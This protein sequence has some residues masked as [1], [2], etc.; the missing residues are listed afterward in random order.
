MNKVK[1][2]Y[3]NL[4][5]IEKTHKLKCFF[6]I[7]EKLPGMSH[8][9]RIEAENK[10]LS[11]KVEEMKEICSL[12]S[13]LNVKYKSQLDKESEDKEFLKESNHKL[14]LR[15]NYLSKKCNEMNERVKVLEVNLNRKALTRINQPRVQIIKSIT[16]ITRFDS[17]ALDDLQKRYDELDTEHKDALN[18]ID[19]LE[20][21]LDDVIALN[22]PC[23]E[24]Y[25]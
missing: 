22:F 21:E 12:T 14:K 11:M 4:H 23:P 5:F 7:V 8:N 6:F 13:T 15:L 20:F 2:K 9:N 1:N 16:D 3:F 25:T 10:R 17:K 18:V 19:E 24:T